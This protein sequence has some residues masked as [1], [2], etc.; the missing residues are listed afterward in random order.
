MYSPKYFNE[1]MIAVTNLFLT[2]FKNEQPLLLRL[3]IL[4]LL[5]IYFL[6]VTDF[7]ELQE[8]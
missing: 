6:T 5:M 8:E 3:L 4:S 2:D 7:T 1:S